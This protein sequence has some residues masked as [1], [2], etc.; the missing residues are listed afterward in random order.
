MQGSTPDSTEK[1]RKP[2]T[3]TITLVVGSVVLLAALW[4]GWDLRNRH[5]RVLNCSDGQRYAIDTREFATQYTAYSLKLEGS[6]NDKAKGSLTLDPVQHDKLSDAIESANEFRKYLVSGYNGCAITQIQYAKFGARFQV[7]DGLARQIDTLS[8]MPSRT[9]A[10]S[11]SLATL[12][13]QYSELAHKLG[14]E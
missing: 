5:G 4:F 10:D 8:K 12:I 9:D 1:S 7:L 3:R 2:E 6:L 13:D 11:A 14:T